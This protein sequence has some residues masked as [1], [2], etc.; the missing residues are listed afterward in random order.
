[1]RK[2]LTADKFEAWNYGALAVRGLEFEMMDS[3]IQCE[4][5]CGPSTLV[6]IYWASKP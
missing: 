6:E 2:S 3:D 1:M 5:C 4:T